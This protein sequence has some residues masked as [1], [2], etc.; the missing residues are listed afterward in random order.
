MT[1]IVMPPKPCLT[2][3][4]MEY[5]IDV[6]G[7]EPTTKTEADEMLAGFRAA[8]PS[9]KPRT[10][11]AMNS[12]HDAAVK[13]ARAEARQAGLAKLTGSTAQK[14]WAEQIR[15]DMLRQVTDQAVREAMGTYLTSAK[16]WIDN[17]TNLTGLRTMA[18]GRRDRHRALIR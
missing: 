13:T 8:K 16:D 11:P 3:A 5:C 9:P 7:F 1:V 18:L 6:L 10:S 4:E 15:Q 2:V 14:R 12:K 17:R